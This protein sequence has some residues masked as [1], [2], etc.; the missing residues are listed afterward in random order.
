MGIYSGGFA[1]KDLKQSALGS[2]D[3]YVSTVGAVR[4]N[5][6]TLHLHPEFRMPG[7]ALRTRRLVLILVWAG[8]TWGAIFA[9]SNVASQARLPPFRI[10]LRVY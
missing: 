8:A 9:P 10:Y 3:A 4:A 7:L 1:P 6:E 5:I 2:M